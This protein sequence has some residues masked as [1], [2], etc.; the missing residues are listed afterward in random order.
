M[1]TIFGESAGSYS[2]S[3]HILSPI[4][5]NLFQRAILESGAQFSQ[6]PQIQMNKKQALDIAKQLSKSFNCSDDNQWL[7]C[8]RKVDANKLMSHHFDPKI[9]DGTDFMPNSTEIAFKTGN[10]RKGI[11]IMAGVNKDEGTS[12]TPIKSNA[13]LTN[14][15]NSMKSLLSPDRKSVV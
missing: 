12:L 8:L 15:M 6:I 13:T 5:R 3:A 10:F 9:M 7:N 14:V 4:S 1:I 2:V 11:Q